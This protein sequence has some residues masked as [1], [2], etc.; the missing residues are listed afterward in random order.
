M[1]LAPQSR[2]SKHRRYDL[3]D[4]RPGRNEYRGTTANAFFEAVRSWE[5]QEAMGLP[6]ILTDDGPHE[7]AGLD[8]LHGAGMPLSSRMST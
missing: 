7:V 1:T 8:L 5:A 3:S 4:D 2:V 6:L